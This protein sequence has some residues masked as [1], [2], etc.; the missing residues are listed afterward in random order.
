MFITLNIVRTKKKLNKYNKQL[1]TTP[2]FL[3]T[4][5]IN[6]GSKPWTAL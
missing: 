6:L 4:R 2:I 1:K 5:K 3:D